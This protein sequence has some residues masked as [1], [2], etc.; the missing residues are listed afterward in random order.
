MLML[1]EAILGHSSALGLHPKI[2]MLTKTKLLFTI[3]TIEV[4][5]ANI[6]NSQHLSVGY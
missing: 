4:C 5:N 2:S 6:Y 3:F 1:T